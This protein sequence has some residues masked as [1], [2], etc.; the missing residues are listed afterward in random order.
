MSRSNAL[1]RAVLVAAISALTPACTNTSGLPQLGGD[2]K[3]AAKADAVE[4][5]TKADVAKTDAKTDAEAKTKRP[6]PEPPSA[7]VK[8]AFSEAL[9]EG[10]AKTT[11]KE[12]EAAIAAFDRAL[13]TIP[14][15]PRALSGRGYTRLLAGDLDAAET[16]LR[17]ALVAPGTPELEAAIAFN[18][19]L[20]AEKRGDLERARGYFAMANTLR[21]SKAAAAKLAA[22]KTC[23]VELLRD[24]VKSELYASWRDVWKALAKDEYFDASAPPADEAGARA[25]VCTSQSLDETPDAP[26]F[27]ACAKSP[28]GP[29]LVRHEDAYSGHAL[30]VLEDADSGQI[31]VTVLA[32]VDI[33]RC[34][35][36]SKAAIAGDDPAI[37]HWEL[38]EFAPSYYMETADGELVDCEPGHDCGSSCSS[39][40]DGTSADFVFSSAT[41]DPILIRGPLDASGEVVA[42]VSTEGQEIVIRSATCRQRA[43]IRAG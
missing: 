4:A 5:D 30:V 36:M 29:W 21:P 13:T 24:E 22:A 17:A 40:G 25:A 12:F 6:L 39:N 43:P 20:V 19:G 23:P 9:N 11:A 41:A 33:G 1:P 38:T 7:E 14:E 26:A 28:A 2:P 35:V 18:L 3:P 16:D 34:G 10:R 15:H 42:E 32:R 31:R 37:V 27:D 8:A